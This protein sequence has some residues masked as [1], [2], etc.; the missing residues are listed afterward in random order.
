MNGEPVAASDSAPQPVS[1]PAP[2]LD[3]ETLAL[4]A[5]PMRAIRFRRGLIIGIAA[6]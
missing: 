4:R 5:R 6:L 1:A 3:P 2:K